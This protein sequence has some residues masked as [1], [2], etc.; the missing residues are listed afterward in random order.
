[1]AKSSKWVFVII[2]AV[3]FNSCRNIQPTAP[4]ETA[5]IHGRV[6][7]APQAWYELSPTFN[8]VSVTIEGTKFTAV[9][10]DSGYF[11]FQNVPTGTYNVRYSKA[12]YG[13]VR[14]MS[15]TVTGG[16]NAGIFWYSNGWAQ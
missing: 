15:T 4:V 3:V 9:S 6:K 13:D 8:G 5:T 1:M 7:L 16:G 14:W 2:A 11:T 12:G 10:D